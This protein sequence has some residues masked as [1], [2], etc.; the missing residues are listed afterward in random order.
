MIW[1][2]GGN[3]WSLKCLETAMA[4]PHSLVH[5]YGCK[6]TFLKFFHR[7]I[8][9]IYTNEKPK[10]QQQQQP[11]AFFLGRCND[12]FAPDEHKCVSEELVSLRRRRVT[13][14][15]RI[16]NSFSELLSS[17]RYKKLC[18]C[19]HAILQTGK[20]KMRDGRE[21]EREV[22]SLLLLALRRKHWLEPGKTSSCTYESI[23]Y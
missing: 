3:A 15:S 17:L 20:K 23:S 16:C 10:W 13:N 1:E 22:V 11:H 19:T 8:L 12:P 6:L 18:C 21:R 5:T 14:G 2:T 7:G 9:Y 4:L